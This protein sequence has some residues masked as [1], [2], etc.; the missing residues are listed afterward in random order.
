MTL[1]GLLLVTKN[2]SFLLAEM[3]LRA[4][5]TNPPT[6][7]LLAAEMVTPA[8]ALPRA[9]LPEE[10]VPIRLPWTRFWPGLMFLRKT[11]DCP[12]PEMRFP[13]PAM[14][15]PMVL[16]TAPSTVTPSATRSEEHTPELQ[17]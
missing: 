2:P 10:S 16:L 1:P 17:P 3:T 9:S 14:T 15:P 13:T 6:R 11:P 4:A 5:A 12:L 8:K 7:L